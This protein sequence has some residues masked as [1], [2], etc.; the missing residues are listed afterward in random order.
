MSRRRSTILGI[1]GI[2]GEVFDYVHVRKGGD[3]G[4]RMVVPVFTG[5]DLNHRPIE[6]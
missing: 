4:K 5:R 2:E 3:R 6:Q 1:R